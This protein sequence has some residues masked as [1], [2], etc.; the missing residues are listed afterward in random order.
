MRSAMTLIF[1]VPPAGFEP[2]H[3][4]PEACALS[5]ELRGPQPRKLYCTA[6]DLPTREIT[7]L[8]GLGQCLTKSEF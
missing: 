1:S 7:E 4:A 2:A 5:P 3:H 6:L 8:V